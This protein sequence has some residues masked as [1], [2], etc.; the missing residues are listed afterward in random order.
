MLGFFKK[1]MDQAAANAAKYTDGPFANATMAAAAT[2]AMADGNLSESEE[3]VIL[4]TIKNNP[5]LKAFNS[6]ELTKMFSTHIENL[7]GGRLGK[8][9]TKEVIMEIAGDT[10]QCETACLLVLDI[11][12]S[13]GD[14]DE[15][16][17]KVARTICTNLDVD[18]DALMD[19]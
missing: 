6:S 11:A 2:I 1:K 12:E 7:K 10:E 19:E 13:D 4:N 16:E 9:M 14:F 3:D 17:Q 18:F 5:T 8:R 15:T